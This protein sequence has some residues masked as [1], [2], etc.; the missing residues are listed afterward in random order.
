M[1]RSVSILALALAGHAAAVLPDDLLPVPPRYAQAVPNKTPAQANPFVDSLL[2][3]LTA[4]KGAEVYWDF[5]PSGDRLDISTA[6]HYVNGQLIPINVTETLRTAADYPGMAQEPVYANYDYVRDAN[7]VIAF[8]SPTA[9]QSFKPGATVTLSADLTDPD[10]TTPYSVRYYRANGSDWTELTTAALNTAPYTYSYGVD[11]NA[12]AGAVQLRAIGWD[13]RGAADTAFLSI[14]VDANQAPA[15]SLTAP[16]NGASYLAPAT[17]TLKASATDADGIVTKVE[18]YK[19]AT[20]IGTDSDGEPWQLG[21]LTLPE[22]TYTFRAVA[23]D[24]GM[25]V[26]HTLSSPVTVTVSKNNAPKVSIGFP[27]NGKTYYAP[28]AANIAASAV[29]SDGGVSKV[30]FYLGNAVDASDSGAPYGYARTF[31]AGNYTLTAKATDGYG[32][33]G[34]SEAVSFTVVTNQKPTARVDKDTNL[35]LPANSLQLHGNAST[36]PE[37]SALKYKWTGPAGATFSNDTVPNPV[38]SFPAGAGSY[39]LTLKVTDGGTPPLSDSARQIVEVRS[40]PAITSPLNAAGAANQPFTYTITATGYPAPVLDAPSRPSWLAFTPPATLSGTPTAKGTYNVTLTASNGTTPDSK[41]LVITIGDSLYKPTINSP[42]NV[43]T[44]AGAAFSYSIT[45]LANPAPTSWGATPLPAGLTLSGSQISGTPAVPGSYAIQLSAVNSQGRDDKNLILAVTQDPKITRDLPDSQVVS[46]KSRVSFSIDASGFPAVSYQWQYSGTAAT[47]PFANVGTNSPVYLIDPVSLASTGWYRVIVKNGSGPD[48]TSKT[49]RL[50]VNPLPAPVKII[51]GSGPTALT[52]VVGD[53]VRFKTKASGEPLP[54]Y[55][56]WFRGVSPRVAVTSPKADDSVLTIDSA[57]AGMGDVY[58]ARVT[59]N[60]RDTVNAANFAWSDTARLVVQLPKLAKPAAS[61]AGTAFYPQLPVTLSHAVPGVTIWY[62]L[63]GQDPTQAAPSIQYKNQPILI[64]S[65]RTLKAKAYHPGVYRASDVLTETYTYTVPNKVAKPIIKPAASTFQTTVL[66]SLTTSTPNAEIF[67][68]LDGSNPAASKKKFDAPFTLS[69]TTTVN[70]IAKLAGYLDSDTAQKVFTYV[71]PRGKVLNPQLTPDGG[72]FTGTL[73]VKAFCPT[74]G[75]KMRYTLDGSAPDSMSALY[76]T[77]VGIV[78]DASAQI[79]IFGFLK[80]N[81]NS[82]VV[83]RDFKLG[84]GPITATPAGG[85]VFDNSVDVKLAASPASAVI[86]FRTDGITPN[87]TSP[88]FPAAGLRLTT[89]TTLTAVAF[90]GDVAG[91]PQSFSYTLRGGPVATPAPSTKDGGFT[92]KDTVS[93]TLQS[94]PGAKIYYTTD[95]SDPAIIPADL[96]AGPILLDK[97]TT[98]QAM[99]AQPGFE[100]SKVMVATYTLMPEK[101][102]MNPPGGSYPLPIGVQLNCKSRSADLY[103]TTDGKDPVP[104]VAGTRYHRGDSIPILFGTTLKAIAVAG[105]L[106]SPVAEETYSRT[107]VGDTVLPPGHTLFLDGGYTLR[108]PEDQN[109]TAQV[110]ITNASGLHLEG[111]DAVQYALELSLAGQPGGIG[112]DFPQL[113]FTTSASEKRALYKV[114]PSGKVYFISSA[115][116]V[117]LPAGTYF[118]GLDTARPR[119]K[120][121]T[122]A[123]DPLDSTRVT[124]EVTDNV[125]NLNYGVN[126]NDDPSR[127]AFDQFVFSGQQVSAQLKHPAGVLKPLYVQVIVSD[128]H[129]AGYFPPDSTTMLSLSQ[130]LGAV[131]GPPAW[132]IGSH[133]KSLYDFVGVPLALDPPLSL[134]ALRALNP[135]VVIEGAEYD[136]ASRKFRSLAEDAPVKA[137]QGYWIGAR[138]PIASLSLPKAATL[139][140]GSGTFSVFLRHGWNQVSNPHLETLYWPFA[141]SLAAYKTFPIKGLW[142]WDAALAEPDYVESDSLLPWRGYFVLNNLGD[143]LVPL[144]TRAAPR[145]ASHAK[146]SADGEVRLSLGWG[147]RAPLN[148]GADFASRDAVGLEDEEALPRRGARYLRAVREGKALVSDW[149]RLERDGIQRWNVSL[150]GEGDSLPSLRVGDAE[151]PDGYEAWAL[152]PARGMK[153]R[154]AAGSEIPP[155]GLAQDSLIV[156]SGPKEKLAALDLLN[157]LSLAAPALDVK[158]ATAPGGFRLRLDLPAKARIRATLWTPD[159]AR[160][161]TL[162]AGPLAGGRYEFGFAEDFSG[163]PARLTPGLYFLSVEC[164]GPDLKTRLSR[165]FVVTR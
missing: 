77:A 21:P 25:P 100:N 9:Q 162:T 163:R 96:Y 90:L 120:Y 145:Q 144:S 33:V 148:L 88:I 119:I 105:N 118:M 159:G 110:R 132:K 104:G 78:L 97:T 103:Y 135:G 19:G 76:D 46:D 29:D 101:P 152:A 156:V 93:V 79:R 91:T 123:Y 17:V 52:V 74:P 151:L 86:R 98:L 143:T 20:L 141:R 99:A 14:N 35:V 44:K 114:E 131:K 2:I 22:S 65:T 84:P 128:Y 111:F 55:Y 38:V 126:R 27:V 133:A 56:Q 3:S 62:T 106:S 139:P 153:F 80:D 140:H 89:T 124:F 158:L 42:L 102:T 66:C 121:I 51:A 116:T 24:D 117:T 12:P 5:G 127:A 112:Q 63:N 71:K 164:Q 53:K 4:E 70:A 58:W 136:N 43:S 59:N 138:S 69:A 155:S 161:G 165:K 134:K 13:G 47:G 154:L 115:D 157:A 26:Q 32:L 60:T 130:K 1:K 36:D 95:G 81:D 39:V 10:A 6:N 67:Y 113:I 108:N 137:G 72:A 109:G 85:L 37:G 45:A 61:P 125:A 15:V 92:F 122:E 50:R 75:A 57:K 48:A 68:T 142:G 40:K 87:D 150:G 64:D 34:T 94:T 8:T 30:D 107:Q 28:F 23:Y 149:I 16:A 146:A 7:P 18:F 49:S 73:T 41:T 54:L 160:Q 82:D 31:A 83:T 147:A 11:A 129:Q